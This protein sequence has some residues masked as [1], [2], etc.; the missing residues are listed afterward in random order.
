ME[1]QTCEDTR[2]GCKANQEPIPEGAAKIVDNKVAM[3]IATGAA[4]AANCE[5]SLHEVIPRLVEA[6]VP[7][8]DIR[9]AM[10]IGLVVKDKPA[11]IMREAADLLTGTTLSEERL[12][13]E[14]PPEQK[15]QDPGYQVTVLIAAG[16]AMAANCEPCLNQVV[17]RLIEAGVADD[18]IRR[19]VEIGQSVK[20]KSA[21]SVKEEVDL[22]TGSL[23]SEPLSA[24][25]HVGAAP[26][27]GKNPARMSQANGQPSTLDR[28]RAA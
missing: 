26:T 10:E 2:C 27:R 14:C 21:A 1:S 5:S 9:E 25:V 13:G 16:S 3:L 7:G 18:D 19:A 20:D 6:G 17:P 28:C 15:K 12:P 22:L 4:I 8:D 11:T 24:P 23:L